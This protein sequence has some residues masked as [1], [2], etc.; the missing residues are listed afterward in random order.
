M[1]TEITEDKLNKAKEELACH[2]MPPSRH[3]S[4]GDA[5]DNSGTAPVETISDDFTDANGRIR[6]TRMTAAGG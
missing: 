2:I 5:A 4:H 6:L 3:Q 1:I